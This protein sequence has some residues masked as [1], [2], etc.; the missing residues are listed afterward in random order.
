MTSEPAFVSPNSSVLYIRAAQIII[1]L[2]C[3]A[4]LPACDNAPVKSQET[5]QATPA[6]DVAKPQNLYGRRA[7]A[8]LINE[9]GSRIGHVMAWQGRDGVLV[10]IESSSL[11]PGPH[12]AHFHR[13]GNCEDVGAYM[14]SGGHIGHGE[15]PHGLLHPEGPHRGNL[16]NIYVGADGHAHAEFYSPLISVKELRDDDGAALIIHERRDDHQSQPIGRSG[17]RIACAAFHSK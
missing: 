1:A 4:S 11:P 7:R 3:L 16:P 17:G 15:G 12:G 14:R 2:S 13:V 10:Q 8:W 9:S 6:E 5:A